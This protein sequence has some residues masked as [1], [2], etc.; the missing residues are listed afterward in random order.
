MRGWTAPILLATVLLLPGCLDADPKPRTVEGSADGYSP[1]Q[2][3]LKVTLRDN[4]T[5]TLTM[6]NFDRRDWHVSALAKHLDQR[7]VRY[8][9][10]HGAALI[11]GELIV[12]AVNA[13]AEVAK[14]RYD[15]MGASAEDRHRMDLEYDALL[16]KLAA[17]GVEIPKEAPREPKPGLDAV[18]TK[19]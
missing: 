10:V 1:T 18:T 16:A 7:E 8:L 5:G 6:A 2:K 13:P 17:Q 15:A 4:E 11:P 3:Y 14:L 9:T 19:V 12:D